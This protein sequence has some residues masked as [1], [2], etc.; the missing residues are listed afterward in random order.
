MLVSNEHGAL[1]TPR[2]DMNPSDLSNQLH[3]RGVYEP[4]E[5]SCALLLLQLR[6]RHYGD[7]VLAIDCG[8]NIGIHSIEWS[9][10]M[11]DWGYVVSLEAQERL[12]YAV[13][14]NVALNNCFN[15]KAINAAV[16]NTDGIIKIPK[17]DYSKPGRYGSVE[18]KQR[19]GKTEFIGQPVSYN[20][21][22][23]VAVRA[24][25]LDS[26]GLSRVDLIKID[27]EGMELETLEG[28][29]ELLTRHKPLLIIEIIKSDR[30][31][32][33]SHLAAL[34]YNLYQ[35]GRLDILAVHKA[36]KCLPEIARRDW[37][38]EII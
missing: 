21:N 4:F 19:P 25:R 9:K 37:S 8:A 15:V 26:L 11:T 18:L 30:N 5:I 3:D 28:A 13:A 34:G 12:Y 27:V 31:Q 32:L 24:I 16:G 35:F 23:L 22:D 36:D 33:A 20:E 7:G 1:I 2:L 29:R 10:L 17:V 38:K 14:G 6:R